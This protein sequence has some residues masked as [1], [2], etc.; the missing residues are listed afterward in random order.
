VHPVELPR[1]IPNYVLSNCWAWV[2]YRLGYVPPTAVIKA[3]L[4]SQGD[5]GYMTSNGIDHYVVIEE[6]RGDTL[7]ISET[8]WGGHKKT[9]RVISRDS[10]EGFYAL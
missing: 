1:P 7:L 9:T 8:N 5:I 10:L 3:N 4:T 6:D 2:Q